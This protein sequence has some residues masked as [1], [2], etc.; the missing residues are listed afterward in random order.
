VVVLHR[1]DPGD[2]EVDQLDPAV[3]ADEDVGRRDVAVDD[4]ERRA[5][6][7]LLVV[8]VV[9]PRGGADDDLQDVL[10]REPLLPAP[11]IARTI[12]RRSCPNTYSIVKKYVPSSSP[13]SYTCTM[14]GWCSVA[15]RRASASNIWMNWSSS[16]CDA[17]IRL[18]ATSFSKP[19]CAVV[20]ARNSSAIPPTAIREI[21][22]YL[23]RRRTPTG[24]SRGLAATAA[25]IVRQYIE[26]LAR[27]VARQRA[28]TTVAFADLGQV[29][30]TAADSDGPSRTP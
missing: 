8:G 9:Q 5:V 22:S 28:P 20:R 4:A 26:R 12:F 21:N 14:F 19:C 24:T 23:P 15:A 30:A 27:P 1:G 18:S 16:A 6:A 11:W 10:R 3:V 13:T 17:R 2:A 29:P 7:A 25:T